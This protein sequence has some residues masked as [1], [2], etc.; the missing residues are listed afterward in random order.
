MAGLG[1][2]DIGRGE[3]AGIAR[4]AVEAGLDLAEES[5]VEKYLPLG[6][7]VKRSHRRLRHAAAPGRGGIAEQHDLRA[8]IV[9]AAGLKNLGPAIVDLAENAR[10]HVAHVV[11]RYAGLGGARGAVG[12]SGRG[13][14]AA[15]ENFGGADQDARI[16]AE[17]VRDKAEHDD[18][19]DAKPTTAH[20]QT[21]AAAHAAAGIVAT[22]FDVGAAAEIIVL[23][24]AFPSL[25][26]PAIPARP[27]PTFNAARPENV[28]SVNQ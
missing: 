6:R 19:A 22:V 20:R 9:L 12:L 15:V 26:F 23:H 21:E 5:G 28:H 18:G 25:K 24:R 11:G 3:F 2:G 10:D 16:D 8:D 27:R 17:G 13:L 14:A 1:R 4:T 7:T